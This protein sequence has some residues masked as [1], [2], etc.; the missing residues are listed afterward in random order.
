[1]DEDEDFLN[2]AE[3]QVHSRLERVRPSLVEIEKASFDRKEAV[4][5]AKDKVQDRLNNMTTLA[6]DAMEM[7]LQSEDEG[8]R[9]K[10]LAMFLDRR[11]PRVGVKKEDEVVEVEDIGKKMSLEEIEIVLKKKGLI[12]GIE[13]SS[14]G[15]GSGSGS[16]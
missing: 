9:M 10:A 13:D 12:D 6:M 16:A 4:S 5:R 14:S 8:I 7:G 1:M 2:F 3:E 11:A 15:S